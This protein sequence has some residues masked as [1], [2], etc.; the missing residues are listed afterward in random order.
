MTAQTTLDLSPPAGDITS[1]AHRASAPRPDGPTGLTLEQAR[2]RLEAALAPGQRVCL[3][4][5]S[6]GWVAGL[7]KRNFWTSYDPDPR[8]VLH[9]LA[10]PLSRAPEHFAWVVDRDA[11]ATLAVEMEG[12]EP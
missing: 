2:A 3:S 6:E 11:L 9:G 4:L 7:T 12:V 8:A 10:S 1:P 5:D